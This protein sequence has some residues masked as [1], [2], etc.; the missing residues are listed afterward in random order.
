MNCVVDRAGGAG[1]VE[2]EV[3]MADVEGLANVVFYKFEARIILQM[4]N[5]R[6]P[7]G[8]QIIDRD[9]APTFAEKSVAEMRSEKSG[10]AGNQS[11]F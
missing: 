3:D 9:H 2:Y 5:I 8:E 10:A 1:E 6:E 4:V 7:A 11:A